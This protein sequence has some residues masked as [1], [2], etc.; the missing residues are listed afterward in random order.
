[1]TPALLNVVDWTARLTGPSFM[2]SVSSALNKWS[3]HII[4]LWNPYIPKVR[5]PARQVLRQVHAS[6]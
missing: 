1:V 2:T 3:G 5:A 6:A 4:P